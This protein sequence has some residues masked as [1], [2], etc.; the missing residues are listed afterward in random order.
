MH[1]VTAV[2]YNGAMAS[3]DRPRKYYIKFGWWSQFI[4]HLWP[5]AANSFNTFEELG[6]TP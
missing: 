2:A 3:F 6:V 1:A 4:R 5:Y